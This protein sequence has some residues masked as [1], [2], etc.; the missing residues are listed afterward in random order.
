MYYDSVFGNVQG[1]GMPSQYIKIWNTA[2]SAMCDNF[3]HCEI[4]SKFFLRIFR[5]PAPAQD[6]CFAAA[7]FLRRRT[8]FRPQP[9]VR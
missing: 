5:P 1:Y 3:R 2:F 9:T 7:K 8:S 4:F 6:N